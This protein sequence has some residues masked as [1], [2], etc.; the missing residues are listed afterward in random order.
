MP[1]LEAPQP[2][3]G[4]PPQVPPV[5]EALAAAVHGCEMAPEWEMALANKLSEQ[6]VRLIRLLERTHTAA[7]HT[8]LDGLEKS[9]YLLLGALVAG[10]PRRA[11]TLADAVHS[12]PS[13]VSRQVAQL[14]RLGWVERQADPDDGRAYMLAAT[15]V[16]VDRFTQLRQRQN[17]HL[18][19]LLADWPRPDREQLVG[20]LDRFVTD[21]EKYRPQFLADHAGPDRQRGET[22]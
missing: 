8:R 20:L 22:L 5:A 10:G 13:T 14:V 15:P 6:L 11:V 18:V 2:T 3:A 12:D 17:S 7:T 16:G 21:F 9:H 19:Q 4:G 1:F